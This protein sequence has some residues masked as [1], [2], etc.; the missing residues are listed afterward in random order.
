MIAGLSRMLKGTVSIALLV[1]CSC[2]TASLTG[3]QA[4]KPDDSAEV[5]KSVA[6]LR[7]AAT[8][9]DFA[10]D[11]YHP[12]IVYVSDGMR[13]D[14]LLQFAL[15]G[16]MPFFGLAAALGTVTQYGMLPAVPPNSAVGWSSLLT[17]ASASATGITNNVF[18]RNTE[19]F[20]SWEGSGDGFDPSNRTAQS[21]VETASNAGK[22]VAVLNWVGYAPYYADPAAT[23][24]VL[25]Y[26]PDWLTGR[27]LV[28]NYAVPDI[29]HSSL[30]SWLTF[31]QVTLVPATDWSNP[32]TSYAERKQFTFSVGSLALQ[33]L[34]YDST[35]DGI[36]NYDRL[37]VATSKDGA[38]ALSTMSPGEWSQ[39]MKVMVDTWSGPQQGGFYSK[40]LELAPDLSHVRLYFT[41]VV[42]P[43]VWPQALKDDVMT[44]F[45]AFTPEDYGPYLANMVDVETFFEQT[46]HWYDL[47]GQKVIP[48]I[49]RT[50]HP[51]LAL[52]GNL[53]VDSVQH[54][55]LARAIP[56]SPMYDP[57]H[58]PRYWQLIRS[59]YAKADATLGKIWAEAPLADI[60]AVSDHGFSPT[61]LAINAEQVLVQAGLSTGVP[62]TSRAR[63]YAAGGTAQIYISLEGRNPHGLV[64]AVQYEDIR[65]QIV[66]AFIALG[67]S[68]VERVLLKEETGA[69]PMVDGIT[70]NMLDSVRTGDVVVFAAPPYQFDAATAGVIFAPAP[71]Y[72]QHG[73]VP[74]G[75]P[76]RYATFVAAGPHIQ[77]HANAWPVT[78]LDIAPTVARILGMSAPAQSQGRVL[79]ILR[80]LP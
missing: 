65:Q 75:A 35:N 32:P 7:S 79:P 40:L 37:L 9:T 36:I 54:R 45:D 57:V 80:H 42:S 33:A 13:Q 47:V 31:D 66:S 14:L 26:Y 76:D 69:I 15:Q 38:T 2:T 17:G 73:F 29:D 20:A 23:G 28:A 10:A 62:D 52:V 41:P 43:R 56:G 72:G 34:I 3:N 49:I 60:I 77:F 8:R 24:P 25:D 63:A 70:A 19:D 78:A 12:A 22:S 74:N 59:I 1:L 68:V 39:S 27:G 53:G 4:P 55:L 58:G 44:R 61:G 46:S 16:H 21:L 50:H 64:P 71:I 18:H 67:P 11:P 48:Y 5:S 51:D 30:S 6:A